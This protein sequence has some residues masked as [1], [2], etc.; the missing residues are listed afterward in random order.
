MVNDRELLK[1]ADTT[2]EALRK[3]GLR[4]VT[5]ESCTGGMVVSLLTA[6]AGAS[7]V[8]EGGLITYS[9]TLKQDLVEVDRRTLDRDGAVSETVVVEMAIGALD[10]AVEANLAIAISG[11]AGP[12]GGTDE[13]PVG[14]V[15]FCLADDDGARPICETCHFEGDRTAVRKAAARHALE[16]LIRGAEARDAA[17]A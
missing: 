9:N 12:D 3:R 10:C 13:K 6:H 8:V 11:I 4:V 5:V 1:L 16:L 17:S 2:I 7:D 14:T 15:C